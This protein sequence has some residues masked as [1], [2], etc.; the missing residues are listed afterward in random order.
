MIYKFQVPRSGKSCSGSSYC[1]NP[2][3]YPTE[4]IRNLLKNQT[5]PPGLFDQMRKR[6]I[7]QLEITN[8][9]DSDDNLEN[10]QGTSIIDHDMIKKI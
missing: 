9:I 4:R 6:S 1:E 2:S 10:D 7:V 8:N 5:F 3:N